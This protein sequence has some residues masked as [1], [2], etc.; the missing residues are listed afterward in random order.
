[1]IERDKMLHFAVSMV[2]AFGVMGMTNV[3]V[4]ATSVLLA[5]CVK[6]L[7]D[8]KTGKHDMTEAWWD[9]LFDVAGVAAG[10]AAGFGILP[11]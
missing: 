4:A 5:G 2:A 10:I 11:V 6:E 8:V 7:V 9:I 1:M 3:A